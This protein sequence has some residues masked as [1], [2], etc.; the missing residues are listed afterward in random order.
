ML[1]EVQNEGKWY[2]I[3]VA[4]YPPGGINPRIIKIAFGT[5]ITN[6]DPTGTNWGNQGNMYDPNDLIFSTG[7]NRMDRYYCKW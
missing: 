6:P 3:I 1:K 7:R 5:S 4:G 2:A